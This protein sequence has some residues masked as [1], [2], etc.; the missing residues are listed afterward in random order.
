MR[1]N[2]NLAVDSSE[3]LN[4]CFF[5]FLS[6]TSGS[7]EGVKGAKGF[8]SAKTCSLLPRPYRART[9]DGILRLGSQ[10]SPGTGECG[11]GIAGDPCPGCSPPGSCRCYLIAMAMPARLPRRGCLCLRQAGAVPRR[12]G[13]PLPPQL[14]S[15][16]GHGTGSGVNTP[17]KRSGGAG[18]HVP[19]PER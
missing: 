6:A 13:A 7:A 9:G 5:V 10:C 16:N 12:A 19:S 11:R 3:G 4:L 2:Y 18:G 17:P 1:I 8:T 14:T 15:L